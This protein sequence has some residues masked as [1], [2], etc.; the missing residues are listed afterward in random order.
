M[1]GASRILKGGELGGLGVTPQALLGSYR[2]GTFARRAFA[3]ADP[4]VWNLLS[5]YLRKG[6]GSRQGHIQEALNDVFI[7]M[8][9]MCI[10]RVRGVTIMRYI[11]N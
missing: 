7:S 4:S 8:L 5:D 11:N 9:L 2:R 6:P 1:N 3:V 10:Q